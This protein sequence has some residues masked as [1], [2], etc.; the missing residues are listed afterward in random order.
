MTQSEH[1]YTE[2]FNSTLNEGTWQALPGGSGIPGDG[3]V[4]TVTD[5]VGVGSTQRFYKLQIRCKRQRAG[6]THLNCCNL[7]KINK[8]VFEREVF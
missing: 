1:G 5:G 6:Q 4:K 8:R 3:T 7:L 2:L